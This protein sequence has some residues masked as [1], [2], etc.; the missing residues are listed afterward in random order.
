MRK[1]GK[2]GKKILTTQ[3]SPQSGM[4]NV[5]QSDIIKFIFNLIFL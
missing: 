2:G 4:I 1:F 5:L 3:K